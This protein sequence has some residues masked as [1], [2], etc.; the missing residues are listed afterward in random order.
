MAI[1]NDEDV[2]D[3][4]QKNVEQQEKIKNQKLMELLDESNKAVMSAII[5]DKSIDD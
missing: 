1:E 5:E 3:E 4:F 2:T